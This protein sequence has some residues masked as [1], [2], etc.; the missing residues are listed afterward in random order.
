MTRARPLAASGAAAVLCAAALAGC[1]SPPP[2]PPAVEI[3]L[4][5]VGN[6]VQICWTDDGLY[7]EDGTR[8]ITGRH[9]TTL[10]PADVVYRIHR[11]RIG[12]QFTYDAADLV[13]EVGGD[14]ADGAA[15]ACAPGLEFGALD[16]PP[17][18]GQWCYSVC[19]SVDGAVSGCALVRAIGVFGSPDAGTDAATGADGGD[20]G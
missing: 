8:A 16:A 12:E 18:P 20:A 3:V 4:T 13:D 10:A 9:H 15:G 7:T 2:D 19:R 1:P 17:G 14:V 5:R 11:N 6:E